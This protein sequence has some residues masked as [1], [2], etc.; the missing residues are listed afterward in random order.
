MRPQHSREGNDAI[1]SKKSEQYRGDSKGSNQS[2]IES[3]GGFGCGNGM[4]HGLH[5]C[6][7]KLTV[8]GVYSGEHRILHMLWRKCGTQYD[9]PPIAEQNKRGG[10]GSNQ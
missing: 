9:E 2:G 4:L 7:R 5:L 3:P 10:G 8:D 6:E 1:D